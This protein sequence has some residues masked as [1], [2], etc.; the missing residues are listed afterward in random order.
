MIYEKGVAAAKSCHGHQQVPP[1][2]I[3]LNTDEQ[4][5]RKDFSTFPAPKGEPYCH[6]SLDGSTRQSDLAD[7]VTVPCR[8]VTDLTAPSSLGWISMIPLMG[9]L[10]HAVPGSCT[11]TMSPTL[12]VADTTI[13]ESS[14][15]LHLSRRHTGYLL[16]RVSASDDPDLVLMATRVWLTPA[17]ICL[18]WWSLIRF[19][20]L[21]D[22]FSP[23]FLTG[24]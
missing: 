14:G 20:L 24:R 13:S 22:K 21:G 1:K 9:H 4:L 5:L 3:A 16:H 17:C 15:L 12:V 8:T 11:N 19:G 2:D 6:A 23:P 18:R 10:T 7:Q